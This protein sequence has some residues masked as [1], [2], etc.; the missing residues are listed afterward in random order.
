M[1]TQPKIKRL[2]VPMIVLACAWAHGVFGAE[3]VALKA[4]VPDRE[5]GDPPTEHKG[6]HIQPDPERTTLATVRAFGA[7]GDGKTDDTA[8]IQKAVDAG[9]GD[10][11][12]PRGVYH[13]AYEVYSTDRGEEVRDVE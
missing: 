6:T 5:G 11:I 13:I 3:P 8:A 9:V 7:I 10:V 12:L 4:K 1:K 2:V